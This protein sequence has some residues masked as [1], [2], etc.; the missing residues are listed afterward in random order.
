[1]D[2]FRLDFPKGCRVGHGPV[3]QVTVGAGSVHGI[4]HLLCFVFLVAQ[5]LVQFVMAVA[6]DVSIKRNSCSGL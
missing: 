3:I 5:H 1:M 2:C 4:A 6:A